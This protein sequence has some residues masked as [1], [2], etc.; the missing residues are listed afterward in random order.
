MSVL[1]A[2][3]TIN[4]WLVQETRLTIWAVPRPIIKTRQAATATNTRVLVR[5]GRLRRRAAL[6]RPGSAVV[7]V[8]FDQG[9][10]PGWTKLYRIAD[11]PA[12][13]SARHAERRVRRRDPPGQAAGY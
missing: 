8:S 2:M 13:R 9:L 3:L 10:S 6:V 12:A 7:T 1:T 11:R 5:R 4:G